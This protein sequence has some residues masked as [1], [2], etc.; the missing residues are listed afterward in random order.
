MTIAMWGIVHA[1]Q[2]KIWY[3]DCKTF[4]YFYYPAE[5]L[6]KEDVMEILP[7]VEEANSISEEMDKKV[8]FEAVIVSPEARGVI[9]GRPEVGSSID[10]ISCTLIIQNQK[11]YR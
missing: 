7:A 11:G 5:M 1:L 4:H 8:T 9:N 6:L 3:T 2:Y 10:C